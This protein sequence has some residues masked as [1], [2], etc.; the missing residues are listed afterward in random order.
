MLHADATLLPPCQPAFSARR[1]CMRVHGDVRERPQLLSA[2]LSRPGAG[3]NGR[4]GP[5]LSRS[6][7]RPA[8][9]RHL[10]EAVAQGEGFDRDPLFAR[11]CRRLGQGHLP[12]HERLIRCRRLAPV[13]LY[14]VG[15]CVDRIGTDCFSADAGKR[16]EGPLA[17]LVGPHPNATLSRHANRSGERIRGGGGRA[18]GIID[19]RQFMGSPPLRRSPALAAPG[20]R[21]RA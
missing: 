19:R 6:P 14:T 11:A 4:K 8:A 5:H 20:T 15:V 18:K 1:S 9:P 17:D 3:G 10:R 16:R 12:S 13:I 7:N 2:F 21:D